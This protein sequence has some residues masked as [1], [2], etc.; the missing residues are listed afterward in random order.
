M[1]SVPSDD[2]RRELNRRR[3]KSWPTVAIVI[4]SYKEPFE[5]CKMTF[6]TA[7]DV[8]SRGKKIL[9]VVDNSP[10]PTDPRIREM[11]RLRRGA[12]RPSR[13]EARFLHNR[14]RAGLKPGN[15]DAADRALGGAEYVLDVDSSLPLRRRILDRAIAQFEADPRLGFLQFHTVATNERF[16]RLTRAIAVNQNF[17]RLSQYSRSFGGFALFYGRNGIWRH[18]AVAKTG[19]WLEHLPRQ[20]SWLPRTSSRA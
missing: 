19:P 7:R 8:D 10:D 1:H 16:N 11:A 20:R 6:D 2:G 3:R 13:P 18:V 17:L 15:L 9:L 14:E 4:P 5:V 12:P